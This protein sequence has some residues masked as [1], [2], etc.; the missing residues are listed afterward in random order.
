MNPTPLTMVSI[1]PAGRVAILFDMADFSDGSS[2]HNA[3]VFFYNFDLTEI[4]N[5]VPAYPERPKDSTLVGTVP[6]TAT[7]RNP[8]PYPT[9]IPDPNDET[10]K[11]IQRS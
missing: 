11:V 10:N 1:A 5:V 6:A 8:T 4:F 7:A 3:Y 2:K 9:P